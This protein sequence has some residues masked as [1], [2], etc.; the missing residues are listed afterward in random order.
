MRAFGHGHGLELGLG[1]VHDKLKVLMTE[2]QESTK[3]K[4]ILTLLSILGLGIGTAFIFVVI[5]LSYYNPTGSYLAKNVLISPENLS[6]MRFSETNNIKASEK[7]RFMLDRLEF[8]YFDST[9]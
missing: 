8:T 3:K 2:I 9:H 5:M 1:Q 6:K 7:S 4:Q